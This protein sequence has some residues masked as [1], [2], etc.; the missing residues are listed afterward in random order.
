VGVVLGAR[1][2]GA[3]GVCAKAGAISNA[4]HKLEMKSVFMFLLVALIGTAQTSA[5]RASFARRVRSA[6]NVP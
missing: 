6:S 4:E 3:G 1:G 2:G 5:L